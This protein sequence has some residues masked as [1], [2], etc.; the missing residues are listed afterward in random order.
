[1]ADADEVVQLQAE[2]AYVKQQLAGSDEVVQ[3][4]AEVASKQQLQQANEAIAS[5][6]TTS[7]P[8]PAEKRQRSAS[9]GSR[10][11]VDPLED[12]QMLDSVLGLLGPL[13]YL[14]TAAVCKRWKGRYIQLFYCKE[15][16]SRK[17]ANLCTSYRK[18]LYTAPRLKLALKSSLQMGM[19]E[20][21]AARLADDIAKR[22]LEPIAVV[23]MAKLFS[24]KWNVELCNRAAFYGRLELLQFLRE[25]ST[26]T[27][28]F[29]NLAMQHQP[30]CAACRE[31]RLS[32]TS[33]AQ[34]LLCSDK[35]N[36]LACSQHATAL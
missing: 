6:S 19:L 13:D 14:F 25:V 27:V 2:V 17:D 26:I 18:A 20:S 35:H 21:N 3:L 5:S 31:A 1:M 33:A 12:D 15:D 36:L 24:M 30:C 8:W 16:G 32:C 11:C 22:S 28:T 34:C 4:Q 7:L 10:H 23:T 9:Y 29:T